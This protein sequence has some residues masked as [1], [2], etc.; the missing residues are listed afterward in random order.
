LT[1][2]AKRLSNREI[3]QSLVIS[4]LTVRTHTYNLY[5]KL[6]VKSRKQAVAKARNLGI[7]PDAPL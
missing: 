7:L 2:L 5:Q 3:A 4:P 6:G 1:L